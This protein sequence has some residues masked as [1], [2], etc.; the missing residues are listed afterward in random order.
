L[1]ARHFE[2][3]RAPVPAFTNNKS[4][5][6]PWDYDKEPLAVSPKRAARLLGVGLTTFYKLLN[7]GKIAST[8]HHGRRLVNYSSL[9]RLVE[10]E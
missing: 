3:G 1:F 5:S 9:R 2:Q 10:E 4:G 8:L 7:E 6:K